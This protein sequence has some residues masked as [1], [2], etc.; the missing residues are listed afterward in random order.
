[1][2]KFAALGLT[3]AIA[4]GASAASAE[5]RSSSDTGF[6]VASTMRVAASPADV[7]ATIAAPGRW[8][9][10]AHT[11]SGDAKNLTI[12][13]RPGG[14][15]CEA[16]PDGGGVEHGRVILAMPGRM[17]RIRG[18]LG[19]LQGEAVVGTLTFELKPDGKQTS[20]TM[21]YVVGG[22]VRGG[23]GALALPVDQVMVEQI[24]RLKAV[25]DGGPP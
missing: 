21:S 2:R 13:A 9:S 17:L 1:M 8:W 22:Y 20:L 10:S 18:A 3:A 7:Y 24:A 6:E 11:Y 12:D 14:C 23:A 25:L 19:P 4:S 15:F 5:V 16:L